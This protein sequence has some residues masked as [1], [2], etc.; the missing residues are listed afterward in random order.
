M[1]LSSLIVL[2]VLAVPTTAVFRPQRISF[3]ALLN[4]GDS[5]DT[6]AF[7]KALTE[8]GMVSITDIPHMASTRDAALSGLDACLSKSQAAQEHVFSDGTHR[9]TLAT[10]SVPD[11]IQK[12]HHKIG[13]EECESFD[14][15][16]DSFRAT[17][18]LA[19][20]TFADRLTEHFMPFSLQD[21]DGNKIEN[22][23]LLST[24]N[25]HL[26]K[27]FS[28]VVEHG[29]HLEHFHSYTKCD[30]QQVNKEDEDTIELHVDQGLFIAFTPG[31]TMANHPGAAAELTSGFFVES[32]QGGVEEVEFGPQD[33]LVFM[34]GDGVNQYINEKLDADKRVR[35]VPHTLRF[36]SRD[37]S[38]TRVWY[39]RMVLPPVDAVHPA[40][41]HTFGELRD[42]VIASSH[43][44]QETENAGLGCSGGMV[45]RDLSSTTCYEDSTYCWH[46]CMNHTDLI[47]EDTCQSRDLQVLCINPRM[48][49]SNGENHGDYYLACGDPDALNEETPF[50]TLPEYPRSVDLCTDAE[51]DAFADSTGYD[52]VTNLTVGGRFMWS[53]DDGTVR[54]RIAYNGL[55]GWLAFGFAN[56]GGALNGMLGGK[57]KLNLDNDKECLKSQHHAIRNHVSHFLSFTFTV[58]QHYYGF[59]R[60]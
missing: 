28:E 31:R 15:A 18:A 32:P 53:I 52:F 5:L 46:R 56:V 47:S 22:T 39:G 40:H 9:M 27:T 30:G 59:A 13:S 29:E 23:S 37:C 45:A 11:G 34:L 6:T 57:W 17:V 20:Q 3:T 36:K 44:N 2:A 58:S 19:T 33:D 24:A 7:V 10:H 55:F 26:F 1:K 54:G 16:S 35:S 41:G 25:G 21:Q 43:N 60:R 12:I 4:G 51:F 38:S 14:E 49:V 50:P 42:R 48:Q 8:S